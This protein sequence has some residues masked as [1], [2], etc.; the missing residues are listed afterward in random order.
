MGAQS[1]RGP[2]GEA[3]VSSLE[4]AEVCT[5]CVGVHLHVWVHAG[6]PVCSSLAPGGTLRLLVHFKLILLML[7]SFILLSLSVNLSFCLTHHMCD[8]Y[9]VNSQLLTC[10]HY[11]PNLPLENKLN[12]ASQGKLWSF[13]QR[14]SLL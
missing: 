2:S 6:H 5:V 3:V 9:P 12:A 4:A 10:P 13:C 11:H 8:S 7:S 14:K 1:C